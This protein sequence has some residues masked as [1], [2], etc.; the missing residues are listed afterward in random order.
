MRRIGLLLTALALA[1]CDPGGP[2]GKDGVLTFL[3][4]PDAV[5]V[6]QTGTVELPHRHRLGNFWTGKGLIYHRTKTLK[7]NFSGTTLEA[8]LDP[9]ATLLSVEQAD[10]DWLLAYRCDAN[11]YFELRVR[12]MA[13]GSPRYADRTDVRCY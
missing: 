13:A 10:G 7:W 1:A 2:N 5:E 9:G 3:T 6:G 4:V 11:G 12:V 8:E